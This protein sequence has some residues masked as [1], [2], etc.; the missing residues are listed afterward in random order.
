MV[1]CQIQYLH[2]CSSAK[3]RLLNRPVALTLT[4]TD[5][6]SGGITIYTQLRFLSLSINYPH[7]QVFLKSRAQRIGIVHDGS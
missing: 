5:G 3:Y 7:D 4:T 2:H 1:P 6:A